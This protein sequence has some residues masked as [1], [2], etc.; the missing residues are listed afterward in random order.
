MNPNGSCEVRTQKCRT[1][2]SCHK[3]LCVPTR[4]PDI[5]SMSEKEKLPPCK[6]DT[7]RNT[8]GKKAGFL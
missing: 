4:T 3:Y 7:R 6:K 8:S 1:E 5:L 2:Q